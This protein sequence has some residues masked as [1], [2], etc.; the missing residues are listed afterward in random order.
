MQPNATFSVFLSDRDGSA[1]EYC[2]GGYSSARA[3]EAAIPAVAADL[4]VQ[5]V[6]YAGRPSALLACELRVGYVY[7]AGR[8]VLLTRTYACSD[9][10]SRRICDLHDAGQNDAALSVLRALGLAKAEAS[11][12]AVAAAAAAEA[13]A[14]AADRAMLSVQDLVDLADLAAEE[15]AAD[16][17]EFAAIARYEQ[18][19]QGKADQAKLDAESVPAEPDPVLPVPRVAWHLELVERVVREAEPGARV[20]GFEIEQ[21]AASG[22]GQWRHPARVWVKPILWYAGEGRHEVAGRQ[23]EDAWLFCGRVDAR[24][25]GPN[26]GTARAHARA[27]DWQHRLHK[28]LGAER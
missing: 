17:R 8:V 27:R 24:Y 16:A 22:G 20:V 10:V 3:A 28:V 5:C 6:S 2:A 26:S 12:E 19:A 1:P 9:A 23:F 13:E 18:S 4:L 14:E 11:A 25:S 15:A 21:R 7:P